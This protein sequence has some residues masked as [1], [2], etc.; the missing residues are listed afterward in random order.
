MTDNLPFLQTITE[1]PAE[2]GPRLVY[3]DWLEER[4]EADRAEFI[5]LQCGPASPAAHDRAAALLAHSW[6]EWLAPL[7]AA[8][9]DFSPLDRSQWG[10]LLAPPF[11]VVHHVQV[12]DGEQVRLQR[13]DFSRGSADRLALAAWGPLNAEPGRAS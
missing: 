7:S 2:D 11:G 8:L 10:Y 9:D 13:A 4:G 1:S 6:P 3:A 5:R 12:W